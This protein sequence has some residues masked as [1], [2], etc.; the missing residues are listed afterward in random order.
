LIKKKKELAEKR[1]RE[2]SVKSKT[3][4]GSKTTKA[5]KSKKGK[6]GMDDTIKKDYRNKEYLIQELAV[7]WWY[8]WN[9]FKDIKEDEQTLAK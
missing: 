3:S 7:R 8:V 1:K 2:G 5:S 6:N 9:D 4:T